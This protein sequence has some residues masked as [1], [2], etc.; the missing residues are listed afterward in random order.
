MAGPDDTYSVPQTVSGSGNVPMIIIA[1]APEPSVTR[2]VTGLFVP[3]F[4]ALFIIAAIYFFFGAWQAMTDLE[5]QK[6]VTRDAVGIDRF[7]EDIYRQNTDLCRNAFER[8]ILAMPNIEAQIAN[9][10]DAIET[11]CRNDRNP[12]RRSGAATAADCPSLSQRPR[13]ELPAG[14]VLTDFKASICRNYRFAATPRRPTGARPN[15]Q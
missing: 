13:T 12:S 2:G 11:Q 4:L 9:T 15:G 1:Q 7:V 14:T 5:R 10:R 3:I 8:P 6:A